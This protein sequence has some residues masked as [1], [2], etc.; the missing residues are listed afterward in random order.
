MLLLAMWQT[1]VVQTNQLWEKN[2][3]PEN[4]KNGN[5]RRYDRSHAGAMDVHKEVRKALMTTRNTP[6]HTDRFWHHTITNPMEFNEWI[7]R[8][9]WTLV[10]GLF[11]HY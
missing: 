4:V 11:Q 8:G 2:I 5:V 6:A 1:Y 3:T 9:R 7:R 10:I